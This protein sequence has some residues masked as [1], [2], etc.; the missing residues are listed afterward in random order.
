MA[1][2]LSASAS[3]ASTLGAEYYSF[4]STSVT[5]VSAT[6]ER[7][8]A[9]AFAALSRGYWQDWGGF[10]GF[11]QGTGEF[12][13]GGLG[14]LVSG[15]VDQYGRA[16]EAWGH[17]SQ[18]EIDS[19]SYNIGYLTPMLR[20]A[21]ECT[22]SP[23][24]NCSGV[25]RIRLEMSYDVGT[26]AVTQIHA[27]LTGAAV[28]EASAFLGMEY[29]HFPGYD[30]A[31]QIPWRPRDGWDFHIE[32]ND[33]SVFSGTYSLLLDPGSALGLEFRWDVAGSASYEP[34]LVTP[35][36]P[37]IPL[38][39]SGLILLGLMARRRSRAGVKA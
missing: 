34:P 18:T 7:S 27:P 36:P 30:A 28:A 5:V 33:N 32:A 38:M 1:G 19:S 10:G 20:Y 8:G 29:F 11:Y 17:A 9:D 2:L 21:H 15:S 12:S 4:A 24:H 16:A 37:A 26:Q 14:T 13:P 3:S 6:Y 39:A 22:R 23:Q 35:L 31:N 25:D